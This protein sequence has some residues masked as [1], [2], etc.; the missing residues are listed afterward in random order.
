[1]TVEGKHQYLTEDV[2]T[3]PNTMLLLLSFAL[4]VLFIMVGRIRGRASHF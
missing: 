4:F 1:M 2:I 3:D